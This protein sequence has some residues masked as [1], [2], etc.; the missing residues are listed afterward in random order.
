LN[1]APS[2]RAWLGFI[3]PQTALDILRAAV[4]HGGE[5]GGRM[6]IA[7]YGGLGR[8]GSRLVA[9]A[10][11][12]DH[13]VTAISRMVAAEVPAGV[14]ARLGDA[15]DGDDV[16]KVASEH[17]VVVSAIGPSRTGGRPQAF[18][19]AIATL[20]ENVGTR[21]LVV[22]G[23]GGALEVAPGLR[24]LDTSDFPADRLPETLAH[25]DALELLRDVG[26]LVDWLYFSPAPALT[27][28]P[29]TGRYRLGLDMAVGDEIS[30]DDFAI[31]VAD[32]LEMLHYRRVRLHA[33]H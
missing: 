25:V 5:E 21:R 18:L 20:A 15:A 10:V 31:A 28:G 14:V 6:Q 12:R 22:I 19:G 2:S 13:S 26:G 27:D 32:E 29:R 23:N 4:D 24:L 8:V 11:G 17:D 33:A 7:V 16:A 9:E 30:L 3:Q 1:N